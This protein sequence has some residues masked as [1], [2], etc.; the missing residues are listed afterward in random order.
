MTAVG[1][2]TT[3]ACHSLPQGKPRRRALGT[4]VDYN[5]GLDCAGGNLDYD[6]CEFPHV[7]VDSVL[8]PLQ[9]VHV[10]RLEEPVV[11]EGLFRV[12]NV[13]VHHHVHVAA[14][15]VVQALGF[16][17]FHEDGL[18]EQTRKAK[19]ARPHQRAARPLRAVSA[20]ER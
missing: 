13:G 7:R 6:V 1:T 14:A 4:G 5:A 15:V 8:H 16:E 20:H 3:A 2:P 11:V 17:E 12:R 10:G 9:R 19:Q 18:G